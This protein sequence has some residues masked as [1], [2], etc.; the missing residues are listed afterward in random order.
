LKAEQ[1]EVIGQITGISCFAVCHG[2]TLERV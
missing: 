2:W 1:R